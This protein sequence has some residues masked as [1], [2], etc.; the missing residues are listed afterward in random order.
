MFRTWPGQVAG[1][2]VDVVGE[3]LPRSGDAGHLRLAAQFAFRTDFAG[4]ARYFAGERVE[5]I[6]HR[7]DGVLQFENFAFH[8]DRDL[9]RQIAAG[10]SGRHFGDVSN[11]ASQV[12]GHRVHRVGKIFPGS[13]DTGDVGLSAQAAFG[14]DFAGHAR[15]FAGE[16][17]ELVDHRVE[18][19]FELQN[20]A[21]HVDRDLARQI[22]AGD[23][24]RDFRDVSH[25]ARQ[26]AGHEVHVVG[27]IFPRSTDAGHLRLTAELAFRT[28][29]ASHA[30]YFA[31]ECIELVHHRVDGVFQFENFTLHVD[32]DLARQIA[33]GHS[34]RDLGD[35]TDLSRQVAG[36]RVHGVRKIFPGSGDAG[37]NCLSAEFAVGADFAGHARHFRCERA[38]LVHHRVDGFFELQ[39]FA[40][41]VD[42]DL[43]G[44]ITTGHGRGDFGDVAHLARQVAGHE[45]YVVGEIFPGTGNIR[46]L[47]LAAQFAFGSHFARHARHLG[48]EHAELLNH[49][50]DEIGGA[51]KLAFQRPPIHVQ[52]HGLSKVS[53]RNRRDRARNFGRGTQQ[54]FH[55]RVD[56]NFHLSPCAPGLVESGALSRLAL[57]ADY[58]ADAL[59]FLR[60]VLVGGNDFVERVGNF[61][62]QPH[63]RARKSHREVAVAHALQ[64]G[65]DDGEI[66]GSVRL[67]GFSVGL[68]IVVLRRVGRNALAI[69][70]RDFV[71]CGSLHCLSRKDE[72]FKTGIGI[73]QSVLTE[74]DS[75]L[76][77]DFSTTRSTLWWRS[78]NIDSNWCRVRCPNGAPPPVFTGILLTRRAQ[79]PP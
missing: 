75:C 61:S 54:V 23:G 66:Q 68:P 58:L 15:Y 42:R 52:P 69:I 20:F 64:A 8:V 76:D 7:V 72:Y 48:R 30:R 36:H 57:L 6:H 59:Q 70:G 21:A 60:H 4:H 3:I 16:P 53:L 10:H 19:F 45:V 11:L 14:T 34:R 26:V 63:P 13:G 17:V 12:A 32:R 71:E 2:E 27:E 37:H 49:R 62:G 50:V 67:F 1:H 51:Q 33:A 9:A 56:R 44:Q 22:A 38:Q 77:I 79:R 46:H 28:D 55:Q 47:R 40:A 29:F 74:A 43:A 31:C 18:R 39:N 5:L 35:V 41:H 24:G 65:Q 73:R 78:T 25:L